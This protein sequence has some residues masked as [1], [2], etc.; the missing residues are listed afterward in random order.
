MAALA[1]RSTIIAAKALDH[2]RTRR[3]GEVATLE[4]PPGAEVQPHVPAWELPEVMEKHPAQ[5]ANFNSCI[6]MD[7]PNRWWKPAKWAGRLQG[8]ESLSGKC[9]CPSWV[10]HVTLLVKQR[11]AEAA[12]YP[13]KLAKKYAALVIKVFKQ[14]L[15]LEFWRFRMQTRAQE[16]SQLQINWMKSREAKTPPPITDNLQVINSKRAWEAGDVTKDSIASSSEGSKKARKEK[17]NEF[18]LWG[19]TYRGPGGTSLSRTQRP[20]TLQRRMEGETASQTPQ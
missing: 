19:P 13:E 9:Q 4:N 11:T 20:L 2:Q 15:Q 1:V 7:W 8:I 12:V 16:P 10:S 18:C 17:E 6:H 5:Q 3:V 14:N